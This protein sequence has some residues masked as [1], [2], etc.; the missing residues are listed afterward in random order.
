MV[1]Y[2]LWALDVQ[3]KGGKMCMDMAWGLG[4][5]GQGLKSCSLGHREGIGRAADTPSWPDA[6]TQILKH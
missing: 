2:D 5:K 6:D 3:S 4:N 1:S